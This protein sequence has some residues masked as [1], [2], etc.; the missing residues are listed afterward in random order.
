MLE[1][2]AGPSRLFYVVEGTVLNISCL[3]IYI[4]IWILLRRKAGEF[5]AKS[6]DQNAQDTVN[7]YVTWAFLSTPKRTN[8]GLF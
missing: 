8:K 6:Y 3:L 5:F 4:A 7:K 1:F 2:F